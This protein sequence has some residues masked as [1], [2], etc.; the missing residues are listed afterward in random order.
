M[1]G[2][3]LVTVGGAGDGGGAITGGAGGEGPV[4]GGE[5]WGGAMGRVGNHLGGAVRE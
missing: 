5:G 3:G 1:E 4:T 2:V